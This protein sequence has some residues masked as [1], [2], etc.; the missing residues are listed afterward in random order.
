[1]CSDGSLSGPP[2]GRISFVLSSY[3]FHSR[4]WCEIYFPVH[5]KMFICI[6]N[7]EFSKP[8]KTVTSQPYLWSSLLSTS[9]YLIPSNPFTC[10]LFWRGFSYNYLEVL[11]QLSDILVAVVILAPDIFN[12]EIS[13]PA[14]DYW[15][16]NFQGSCERKKLWFGIFLLGF[17]HTIQQDNMVKFPTK[18]NISD[19]LWPLFDWSNMSKINSH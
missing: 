10:D 13:H 12:S 9:S 17:S 14:T 15:L 8:L 5:V 4:W 3:P 7:E 6:V 11:I 19:L 1:M 2:T 18:D 16:S